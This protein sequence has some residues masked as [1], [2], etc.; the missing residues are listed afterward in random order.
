MTL[1]VNADSSSKSA[2][3]EYLAESLSLEGVLQIEVE[4]LPWGEYLERLEQGNF[5]LYY[6]EVR[7]TADWDISELIG[8]NGTLNYGGWS[9]MDTDAILDAYRSGSEAEQRTLYQHLQE[10]VAIIPICFKSDSLLTHSGVA[11]NMQPTA[12]N[13]FYNFSDWTI[14]LSQQENENKGSS[15]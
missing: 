5:D 4:A 13:I 3:A 1:L 6:G 2:I 11:E 7:L 15:S 8:S 14:H 12:S 9:G 10:A